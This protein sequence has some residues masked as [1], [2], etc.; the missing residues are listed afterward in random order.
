MEKQSIVKKWMAHGE[1]LSIMG[2]IVIC[3]IFVFHETSHTNRRLDDHMDSIN[4]RADE[5]HREFY[6]LLKEMRK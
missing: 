2:T 5:L 4:R 6:A 3:F 1:W